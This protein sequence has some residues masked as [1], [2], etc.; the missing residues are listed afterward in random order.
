V[1]DVQPNE[2]LSYRQWAASPDTGIEVTVTFEEVL[3]GTRI[4]MTQAG[5]GGESIL[6][7]DEVRGGMDETLA[8]LA[9]Y[10]NHGVRFPRHRDLTSEVW[11]GARVRQL[12]AGVEVFDVESDGFVHDA[13]MGAGDVLLQLGRAPVFTVHDIAFFLREHD[14]GEEVDVAWAHGA[15]VHR[16][17]GRLTARDQ[18]TFLAR[19]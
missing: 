1:T 14:A 13:G 4:T 18:K 17:R 9:L 8:D 5:F 3:G 7:S 2:R 6:A 19:V 16:G 15:D 12:P 10:L 11:L